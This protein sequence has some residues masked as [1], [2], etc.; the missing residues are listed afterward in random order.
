LLVAVVEELMLVGMEDEHPQVAEVQE[1]SW[2]H[3]LV[4]LYQQLTQL[5]LE[6]AVEIVF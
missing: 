3:Q 2:I 1:E 6:V 5:Q 4:Y